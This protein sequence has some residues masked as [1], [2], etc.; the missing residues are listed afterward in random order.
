MEKIH[1]FLNN[2]EDS[3][4]TITFINLKLKRLW[5]FNLCGTKHQ[6]IIEF[7]EISVGKR[8]DRDQH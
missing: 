7:G 2:C 1:N 3:Y 8:Q 6:L 5:H 4:L